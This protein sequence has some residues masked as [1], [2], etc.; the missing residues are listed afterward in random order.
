MVANVYDTVGV[1]IQTYGV[2]GTPYLFY[3]GRY[4]VATLH[5]RFYQSQDTLKVFCLQIKVDG[6]NKNIS[7]CL[8]I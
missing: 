7:C 4:G 3:V 2:F 6:N 1:S 5:F 8:N